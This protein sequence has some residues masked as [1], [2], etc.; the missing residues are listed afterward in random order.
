MKHNND[1]IGGVTTMPSGEGIVKE[2]IDKCIFVKRLG[3]FY[4]S[5]RVGEGT[6]KM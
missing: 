3:M 5:E 4:V 1:T 6:R 2:T